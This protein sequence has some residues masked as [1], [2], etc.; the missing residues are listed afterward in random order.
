MLQNAA[1]C[2]NGLRPKYVFSLQTRSKKKQFH[3]CPLCFCLSC[4]NLVVRLDQGLDSIF[5]AV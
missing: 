3:V 4:F 5:Q 2:G 1:L